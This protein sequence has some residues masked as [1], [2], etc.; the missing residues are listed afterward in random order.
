MEEIKE[1]GDDLAIP[2]SDLA[3]LQPT[4]TATD[5]TRAPRQYNVPFQN[6]HKRLTGTDTQ[7]ITA[8]HVDIFAT[9]MP[10]GG[11]GTSI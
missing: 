10:P 4:Y 2:A 8:E 6:E 11:G 3:Y 1:T 9:T 7:H 5:L